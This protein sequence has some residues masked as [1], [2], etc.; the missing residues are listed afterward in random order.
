MKLAGTQTAHI[1]VDIDK[2]EA[3][4][5]VAAEIRRDF[6][7]RGFDYHCCG[8]FPDLNTGDL[9]YGEWVCG[10]NSDWETRIERKATEAELK[11]A[12]VILFLEEYK[13]NV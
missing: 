10:H 3:F 11:A 2:T 4:R 9:I 12:H 13:R 1:D 7:F 6:G 8:L 5:G